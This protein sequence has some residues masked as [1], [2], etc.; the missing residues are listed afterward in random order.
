MRDA[1]AVGLL[2]MSV[3]GSCT[4]AQV[5][6]KENCLNG[7]DDDGNGLVDC[8]DSACFADPACRTTDAGYYGACAKCGQPCV[9][10][11]DCFANGWNDGPLP[12][13][14][15]TRCSALLQGI[16]L[17]FE[18]DSTAYRGLSI[19]P[20]TSMNTRFVMK[21]A[22]DNSTVGCATLEGVASSK[23]QADADQIE[24]SN[25]FNFLAY[26]V[27]PV[28]ATGGT[29]FS[30]PFLNVGTGSNFIIWTEWWSAPP[31]SNTKLPSGTRMGWGC[32][33]SGPEVAEIKP[34]HHWP[35]GTLPDGGPAGPT[36]TSRTI[37]VVLP[38]PQ[39]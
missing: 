30:Q 32:F 38:N 21:A 16:Q 8:A 19:P 13:C 3:A 11:Q 37:R 1:L 15:G 24:R 33:E 26:D 23:L 25:R 5:P 9:K 22:L 34:E 35:T 20:K 18:V 17:R 7:I 14:L 2:A 31:D 28:V 27:T 6:P 36:P 10:P 12:Q 4:P 29:T 39:G